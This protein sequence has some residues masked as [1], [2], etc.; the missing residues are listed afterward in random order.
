M[1]QKESLDQL[2]INTIRFLAIDA[3]QKANSGHPGM[4]MGAAPMA[5][6]L[7]TK[8]LKFDPEDPD[9]PN[10][11][12]F[13]LSAGHGSMLLYSLLYLTGFKNMTM[14][15]LKS[16]RQWGSRT[17]GHP[18]SLLSGGV[19]V[20]TGPLG[21]GFGN[22]VGMAMA[23]CYLSGLFNTPEHKIVD[24]Y[25]YTIASD[26]DLMEGVAAEA[27]SLAGHLGLGKLICL[28]DDNRISIEGS[29]DL[30]FTED[31]GKRF[32]A[33]GWHVQNVEDGNDLEAISDAL[34][35]AQ[36]E[37]KRPSLIIVSTHIGYG[38]PHKQ[39]SAA[40]HGEPLGAKEARLTKEA[41][42]WPLQPD[43]YVP[44]EAL[45]HFRAVGAKGKSLNQEWQRQFAD[46]KKANPE[47]ASRFLSFTKREL[48]QGWDEELPDFQPSDGPMA[49][50]VA[51]G[52]CIN[53]LAPRLPQLLGGS[54]DL[55]PST[56]TLID[57]GGDFAPGRCARNIHFGVR[58]H[59]M[60]AIINGLALHG[61]VIPYGSTFLVFS[62]YMRA[63]IRIGAL[64][65][66]PVIW[67]FTHDSV[68]L[69]EDGPTHQPVEHLMSLRA[70]PNLVIIRPAD[71]C[72]T[73]AAWREA[74]KIQRRGL[75]VALVLTRQKLPV[76][77]N[78]ASREGVSRGAYVF[79]EAPRQDGAAIDL[80][81]IATGSEVHV[82]LD[83]QR[84]LAEK[85]VSARVVSM[86]SWELFEMQDD[87]YRRAV[88]PPGITARISIEAGVTLGWC[89]YVGDKGVAI[90][91]DRF[92]ASAPGD[93]V[94]DKLG[95]NAAAVVE[96]ALQLIM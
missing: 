75:P 34:K 56:K 74:V 86:P 53:A 49:T 2:C 50:R 5:Y 41:L 42:G 54:A 84:L 55:A 92:G 85:N 27:A 90:G 14:D 93:V 8:F 36:Q 61:G 3:I 24:H 64:Q 39:D 7:W 26:G 12:R 37:K 16:F 67:V 48:P 52:K 35:A 6:V 28:Y 70:M 51:S 95:I 76:L 78:S 23:E 68:G 44:E 4:P 62:D 40:A 94:L 60:G 45:A 22:S 83:A 18:E 38:S 91:I 82:A 81:I 21:Q 29:T 57:K 80:I 66:A 13:I 73:A 58:E 47:L 77:D 89:R 59:A 72:E 11:D 63:A 17:P 10:R 1:T 20:T 71:A 43:F 25:T 19:E 9:W 31:R 32:A 46:F 15:E 87:D 30:T 33:Y 69:G 79:S 88:L 96:R 65:K